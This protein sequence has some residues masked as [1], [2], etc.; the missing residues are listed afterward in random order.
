M[1]QTEPHETE[2]NLSIEEYA[3]KTAEKEECEELL[4]TEYATLL[5]V[6]LASVAVL[7]GFAAQQKCLPRKF[8]VLDLP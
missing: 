4:L 6:Y 3:G 8:S 5:G 7:T 2:A 1:E